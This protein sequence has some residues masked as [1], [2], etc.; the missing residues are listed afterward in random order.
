MLIGSL[1]FPSGAMRTLTI[2]C[3]TTTNSLS[4][5]HFQGF[6]FKVRLRTAKSTI[7]HSLG[8]LELLPWLNFKKYVKSNSVDGQDKTFNNLI[9]FSYFFLPNNSLYS[10]KKE[11]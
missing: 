3:L 1:F 9:N 5:R 6:F 4:P 11:T 8:E 7:H 2:D 10:L